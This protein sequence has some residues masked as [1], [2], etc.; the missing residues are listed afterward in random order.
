MTYETN[1]VVHSLQAWSSQPHWSQILRGSITC[2]VC[3]KNVFNCLFYLKIHPP[4]SD[5]THTANLRTHSFYKALHLV[6][7]WPSVS[8]VSRKISLQSNGADCYHSKYLTEQSNP[9]LCW[10]QAYILCGAD[11][12]IVQDKFSCQRTRCSRLASVSWERSNGRRSQKQCAWQQIESC[13][14]VSYSETAEIHSSVNVLT[15]IWASEL[16]LL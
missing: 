5:C 13:S 8:P 15:V 1:I 10:L 2:Q 6:I 12:F 9:V 7:T 4:I 3:H 16:N 11:L 14:L